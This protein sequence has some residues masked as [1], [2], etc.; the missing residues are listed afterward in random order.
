MNY[1]RFF[2]LRKSFSD[3]HQVKENVCVLT[4]DQACLSVASHILACQD[5]PYVSLV[6]LGVWPD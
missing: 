3:F 4:F 5:L 1:L 2:K 6:G